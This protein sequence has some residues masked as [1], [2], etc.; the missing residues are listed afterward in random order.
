[1]T[2]K[3]QADCLKLIERY[4]KQKGKQKQETRDKIY[5]LL[6]PYLKKYIVSICYKWNLYLDKEE[7]ISNSYFAFIHSLNNYKK[8]EVPLP[9]HF[10]R[11]TMYYLYSE[12]ILK[13][14]KE[15]EEIKENQKE[16]NEFNLSNILYFRDHLT[17]DLQTILDDI[18]EQSTKNKNQQHYGIKKRIVKQI[19]KSFNL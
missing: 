5:F 19:L 1:M 9:F 8:K 6:E 3:Q 14:N 17:E 11:N 10:Y 2:L 12:Y 4:E 13:K 18:I 7:I 16:N 15:T